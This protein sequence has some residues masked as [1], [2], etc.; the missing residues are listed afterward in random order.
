MEFVRPSPVRT[1][2]IPPGRDMIR[3][4]DTAPTSDDRS[5]ADIALSVSNPVLSRP[6]PERH[7]G[8]PACP[9]SLRQFEEIMC[10]ALWAD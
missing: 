5:T 10:P 7:R 9:M 4:C 3:L 6:L 1:V 8:L 2:L